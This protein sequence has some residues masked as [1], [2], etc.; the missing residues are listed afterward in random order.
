MR[1]YLKQAEQ[2]VPVIKKSIIELLILIKTNTTFPLT[3][4]L[5]IISCISHYTKN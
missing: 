1:L 4:Q 2:T 3:P 5:I